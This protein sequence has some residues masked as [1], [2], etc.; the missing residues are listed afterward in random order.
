[1][2]S[3]RVEKVLEGKMSRKDIQQMM[4]AADT[5]QDGRIDYQG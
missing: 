5:S 4:A 3:E 2:R 1:M